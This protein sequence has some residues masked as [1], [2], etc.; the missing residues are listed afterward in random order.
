MP[1][2]PK[3]SPSKTGRR[4]PVIEILHDAE[5]PT[6][7]GEKV[8]GFFDDM[9]GLVKVYAGQNAFRIYQASTGL[10]GKNAIGNL[11]GMVKSAKWRTGFNITSEAGEK[12]GVIAFLSVFAQN[13]AQAGPELDAIWTSK[14]SPARKYLHL[15]R[16]ADVI[17]KRTA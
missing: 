11:Q 10:I 12:L 7:K 1:T 6:K 4:F 8:V 9:T 15:V 14:E 17:G 3:S 13:L 2:L 5:A 16:L